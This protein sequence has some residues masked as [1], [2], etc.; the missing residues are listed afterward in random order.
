MLKITGRLP[1]PRPPCLLHS[2]NKCLQKGRKNHRNQQ[3]N[4]MQVTLN[5]EQPQNR[6][7]PYKAQTRKPSVYSSVVVNCEMTGNL[8]N[9]ISF[10]FDSHHWFSSKLLMW[11]LYTTRNQK[12]LS[13]YSCMSYTNY[14]ILTP[15]Y[16]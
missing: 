4:I 12:K 9:K 7:K 11:F 8:S 3:W 15:V 2:Q 16:T 14:L 6:N 13:K 10:A 5:S 1:C